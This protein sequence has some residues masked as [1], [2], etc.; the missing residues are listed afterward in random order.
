MATVKDPYATTP[1]IDFNKPVDGSMLKGQS[2][3]VTGGANGIGSSNY[4]ARKIEMMM[5]LHRCRHC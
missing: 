1:K 3:L 5:T 4:A 2:V